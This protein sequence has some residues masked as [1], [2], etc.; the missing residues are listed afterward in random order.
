M[1][2]LTG[3][4]KSRSD[5]PAVIRSNNAQVSKAFAR[6]ALAG[7]IY[8]LSFGPDATALLWQVVL[9]FAAALVFAPY[10]GYALL[11][12]FLLR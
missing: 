7:I 4:F 9:P 12:F 2:V 1:S 8:C 11:A 10:A 6:L 3:I 5:D